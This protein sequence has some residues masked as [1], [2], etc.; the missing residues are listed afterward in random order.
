MSQSVISV[1][2]QI[3]KIIQN[4]D[5]DL[6]LELSR[7]ENSNSQESVLIPDS[8]VE[9]SILLPETKFNAQESHSLLV[10]N[11]DGVELEEP[12]P[13][14]SRLISDRK[15]LLDLILT[16]W[17]MIGII[18]FLGANIFIFF[19]LDTESLVNNNPQSETPIN[20]IENQNQ[21][22]NITE[23][24]LNLSNVEKTEDN[25][26]NIHNLQPPS[27]PKSLPE[28]N[29]SNSTNN[30]PQNSSLYPDLKS[31]LFG[32]IQKNQQPLI[33]PPLLNNNQN[34]PLPTNNPPSQ[35]TV[36]SSVQKIQQRYYLL[37]NYQNMD[38]FNRIKKIEPNAVIMNLNQEM[39]IQLGIFNTE[40]EA[41]NQ[42][43]K[44]QNQG[45]KIYIQPIN[46]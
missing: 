43:Q 18:L 35:N 25:K 13:V 26:T 8:I 39:K 46:N 24:N 3:K 19:G 11:P 29:N 30:S 4:L 7:Y 45:I 23:N 41:K 12:I 1:H 9:E 16:P 2:P 37:S 32:E 42:G 5:L 28:I 6:G 44:L 34:S 33:P 15:S 22:N 14:A 27:L 40:T 17:G 31:A 38:S 36:N 10:Y 21:E 20:N